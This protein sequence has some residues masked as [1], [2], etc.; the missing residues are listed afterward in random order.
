METWSVPTTSLYNTNSF[1]CPSKPYMTWPLALSFQPHLLPLWPLTT[2]MQ[3]WRPPCYYLNISSFLPQGLC[4]YCL[5]SS[6]NSFY[7][8]LLL[9]LGLCLNYF[10]LRG[11]FPDN[12]NSKLLFPNFI[13]FL[14]LSTLWSCIICLQFKDEISK[15]TVQIPRGKRF[16]TA[17]LASRGILSHKR[18]STNGWG[19]SELT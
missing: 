15:P 6:T 5:I 3:P 2:A 1:S 18:C 13:L 8:L 16:L 19:L 11:T 10:L 17:L 14:A 4:T 12:C 7:H 9:I